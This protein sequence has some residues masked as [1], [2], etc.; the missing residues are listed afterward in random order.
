MNK[1]ALVTGARKGLGLAWVKELTTKGYTVYLSARRLEQAEEAAIS[2]EGTV[3]PIALD[4]TKEESIAKAAERVEAD[5]GKI[6]LLV[7]NAGTNPKDN[8]N[9]ELMES[10]FYLDKL[11]A[12]AMIP[13]LSANSISPLLMMK[14]FRALLKKSDS[15]KVINIS[16]WLGSVSNIKWGYHFAYC[17]SKNLLNMFNKIAATELREDGIITV[18]V[19]PGWVKTDM[20]GSKAEFTPQ[21]SVQNIIKNILD[22]LSM[23][24]SGKFLNHSG[25]E[26]PW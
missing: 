9:K 15:P 12:E 14:H 3:F 19:N 7:N 17:G 26:H 11:T 20:G 23:E 6:D 5:Y 2:I 16:S 1:I 10:A 4:I 21:E 25:E 18:A 13:T 24:D 22:K 8:P